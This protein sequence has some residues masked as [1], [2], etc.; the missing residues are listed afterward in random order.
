MYSFSSESDDGFS[1]LDAPDAGRD[2]PESRRNNNAVE[3]WVT[4]KVCEE[5]LLHAHSDHIQTKLWKRSRRGFPSKKPFTDR[6]LSS[7]NGSHYDWMG[8]VA[9][10]SPAGREVS[11]ECSLVPGRQAVDSVGRRVRFDGL[12]VALWGG[13]QGGR[14]FRSGTW[15]HVVG[16][17]GWLVR[18][19]GQGSPL[20][21]G[22]LT[23]QR[24]PLRRRRWQLP[25]GWGRR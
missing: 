13:G 6:I 24:G 14:G 4:L 12:S 23:G 15:D 2:L 11:S 17:P 1:P 18:G 5:K 25:Q 7:S 21:S 20:E 10:I 3:M 9:E 19:R 8:N 22:V 16:S